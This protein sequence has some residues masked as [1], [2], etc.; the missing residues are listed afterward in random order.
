[1]KYYV[2]KTEQTSDGNEY[3]TVEKKNDLQTA[4]VFFFQKCGDIANAIGKT[5]NFGCIRIET[6]TGQIIRRE[7]I[8]EYSEA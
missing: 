8:G 1:M 7:N 3:T 2:I 5:L 4:E 6:S